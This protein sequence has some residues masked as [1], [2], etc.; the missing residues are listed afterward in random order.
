MPKKKELII[1]TWNK[2]CY[3]LADEKWIRVQTLDNRLES[4]S[5]EELFL[6][7]EKY[8]CL[9]G[10]LEE[11]NFAVL[12]ILL[13]ILTTVCYRNGNN[14]E[15]ITTKEEAIECWKEIWE[16]RAFS[17]QEIHEYLLNMHERFWLIHPDK[18]FMQVKSVKPIDSKNKTGWYDL[19]KL[20]GEIS[21]SNNKKEIRTFPGR[22][23]IPF[24]EAARWLVYYV[25]FGDNAAK[26]GGVGW[27]GKIGPI[28][29]IGD[30]LF[31]TLMYNLV[32]LDR[33]GRVYEDP[34]P[35][36]EKESISD[37][38][39][40]EIDFPENL[41]EHY[42]TLSHKIGLESDEQ[43]VTGFYEYGGIKMPTDNAFIEPMTAWF[44]K[45]ARYR[46]QEHSD[47]SPFWQEFPHLLTCDKSDRRAGLFEWIG[48][49]TE[50][51]ILDPEQ[52]ITVQAYGCFYRVSFLSAVTGYVEH[53]AYRIT[54]RNSMIAS[55]SKSD[56][57]IISEVNS[58]KSVGSQVRSYGKRTGALCGLNSDGSELEKKYVDM[59][60]EPFMSWISSIDTEL[61]LILAVKKDEWHKR[62]IDLTD[63][64]IMVY[65]D[66]LPDTAFETKKIKLGKN[67]EESMN[68][69][70][71]SRDLK[72]QVRKIY[73]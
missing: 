53:S 49:L 19:R 55:L 51:K 72:N 34:K 18:P 28:A 35:Q 67:K 25:A 1:E 43:G 26:N 9:R 31:E 45:G 44:K 57:R 63:K 60:T 40:E 11:Q 23:H 38:K 24:D 65:E 54:L 39:K 71:A 37:I 16:K 33:E 21:E 7:A 27:L 13:A 15:P 66:S 61:P 32:L 46:P 58:L 47:I 4:V 41:P 69:L 5:I 8:K 22:T 52:R 10:E 56:E 36:W 68:A 62:L 30:N 12:R 3:N 42:T 70:I 20:D 48:R 29:I 50:N 14:R 2:P 6:N 73:S 64:F 59:I 17:I